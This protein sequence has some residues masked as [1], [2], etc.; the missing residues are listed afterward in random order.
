M[1][2]YDVVAAGLMKMKPHIVE[3]VFVDHGLNANGLI[4]FEPWAFVLKIII[5]GVEK[6]SKML[7]TDIYTIFPN[8]LVMLKKKLIAQKRRRINEQYT[9]GLSGTKL[10]VRRS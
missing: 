9:R 8:H 7:M 10:C 4:L 3:P 5:N 6:F 2:K 1:G